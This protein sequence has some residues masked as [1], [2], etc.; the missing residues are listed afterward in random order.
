MRDAVLWG[1]VLR[2]GYLWHKFSQINA[3]SFNLDFFIRIFSASGL[4]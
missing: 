2:H 3:V 4:E 1:E